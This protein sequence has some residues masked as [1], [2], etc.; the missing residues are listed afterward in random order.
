MPVSIEQHVEWICDC[1]EHLR[2]TTAVS[3][4]ATP[5]AE[6][7]WVDHV[8]E[9]AELTLFSKASSWYLGANIPGKKRVFLPYV[10]G[11]ASYRQRCDEVAANRYE[12]FAISMA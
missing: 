11:V 9:L 3:I 10:G 1:I 8:A 5:A 2:V 4:E 6:D 12:G 7:G